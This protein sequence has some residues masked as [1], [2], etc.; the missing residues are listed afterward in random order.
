MSRSIWIANRIGWE[1]DDNYY[2][3]SE[4]SEGRPAFAYT[5]QKIA[6]DFVRDLNIQEIKSLGPRVFD[7]VRRDD[8]EYNHSE[9]SLAR[10]D[11]D[12]GI[13]LS[14]RYEITFSREMDQYTDDDLLKIA[15][16]CNILFY[17]LVEVSLVV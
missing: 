14:D 5:D 6:E 8:L 13:D 17:E 12:Y 7:Y 10:F 15:D 11:E 1:Y 16:V 3:K 9:E 2:Y 4:Y